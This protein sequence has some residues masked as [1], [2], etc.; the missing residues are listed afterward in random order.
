M[1]GGVSGATFDVHI[2]TAVATVPLKGI[3]LVVLND[4]I[5]TILQV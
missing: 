4:E 3:L 2:V 1:V 5:R